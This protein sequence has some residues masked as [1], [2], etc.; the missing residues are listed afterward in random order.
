M[1]KLPEWVSI[2]CVT[3]AHGIKGELKVTPW[4]DDPQRFR[5]LKEVTVLS[6]TGSKGL[7]QIESVR[8]PHKS[9]LLKLKEVSDRTTAETFKGSELKIPR[10]ECVQLPPDHYYHFELVGLK[11]ESVEGQFIGI[12][13]DVMDL[14]ANDVYVVEGADKE[15]LIPAIKDV[16]KQIDLESGIMKIFLLDGLVE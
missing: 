16:V 12:I 15:I 3:G 8:F 5:L 2:G 10:E 4:T 13:K 1:R 9:M 6:S 11:V 7:Y 14:P